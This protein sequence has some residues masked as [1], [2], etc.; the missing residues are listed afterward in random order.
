MAACDQECG[1]ID[2][3]IRIEVEASGAVC[4]SCRLLISPTFPAD[5]ANAEQF[6]L[7][8][9]TCIAQRGIFAGES[10]ELGAACG[11]R[12]SSKQNVQAA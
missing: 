3:I 9:P 10:A 6:G 12:G 4:E 2:G 8:N 1:A 11:A 5:W 7:H